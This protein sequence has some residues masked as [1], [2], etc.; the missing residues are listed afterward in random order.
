MCASGG[1]EAF[2]TPR[3]SHCAR[4]GLELN[5]K[6]RPISGGKGHFDVFIT[7]DKNLRHQQNLANREIP[8]SP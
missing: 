3:H 5:Q 7:S 4:Y 6:W 2:A 8:F 1:E